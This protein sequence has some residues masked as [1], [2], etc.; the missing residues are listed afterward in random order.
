MLAPIECPICGGWAPTPTAPL[1][2]TTDQYV[3]AA[4]LVSLTDRPIYQIVATV[5]WVLL[6]F[7][8]AHA[9]S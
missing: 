7:R 4:K 6:D 1:D 3:S 5:D 8:H 2:P 9:R